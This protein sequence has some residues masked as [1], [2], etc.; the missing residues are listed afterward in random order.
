MPQV[1]RNLQV[2]LWIRRKNNN[3]IF[4]SEQSVRLCVWGLNKTIFSV[5]IYYTQSDIHSLNMLTPICSNDLLH[6]LLEREIHSTN[7]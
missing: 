1:R 4:F 2:D 5:I 3:F 6:D 7:T